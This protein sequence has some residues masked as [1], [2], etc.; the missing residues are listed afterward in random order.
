MAKNESVLL[1]NL[2]ERFFRFKL[3][4]VS[5]SNNHSC[6]FVA[7]VVL[8]R[9]A[10]ATDRA[11]VFF[12]VVI[13]FHLV[14]V[15]FFI[16][17]S[18]HV[19]LHTDSKIDSSLVFFFCLFI[20]TIIATVIY[21]LRLT[22]WRDVGM[23]L[24]YMGSYCWGFFSRIAFNLILYCLLS[25]ALEH[26]LNFSYVCVCWPD[27]W[28]L[29]N[30]WLTRERHG[31]PGKFSLRK[32]LYALKILFWKEGQPWVLDSVADLWLSCKVRDKLFDVWICKQ[33]S[34]CQ[35]FYFIG[36]RRE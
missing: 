16:S 32:V 13:L 27:S 9:S 12:I 15:L 22:C 6:C 3:V 28:L 5:Q 26:N 4:S 30:S 19:K 17:C 20:I 10:V 11:T 34:A 36:L 7:L 31:W 25:Q 8:F 24:E 1:W 35:S 29:S 18:E 33:M 2:V 23:F 14:K 21:V